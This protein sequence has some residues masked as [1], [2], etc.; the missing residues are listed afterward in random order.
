MKME[1]E[2]INP[3]NK[4]QAERAFASAD[5]EKIVHALLGT[6]FHEPDWE[7]VE[8]RCLQYLESPVPDLRNTA[9]ICLGH[10]ARIHR[11][12]HKTKVV[13][14]L[15]KYLVDPDY[16]GRV[17]DALDDIEMFVK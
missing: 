2:Q 13:Q 12:L 3:L 7:W 11:K 6:T 14:E 10:L 9:I 5:T 4:Q 1:F 8:S 17:E 16:S 15:S